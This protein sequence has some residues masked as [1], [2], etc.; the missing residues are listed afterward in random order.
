MQKNEFEGIINNTKS[1]SFSV[2]KNFFIPFI[3]GVLGCSLVIRNM[4]WCSFN[5]RKNSR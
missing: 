5:K 3:S 2:G 1:S 4:F